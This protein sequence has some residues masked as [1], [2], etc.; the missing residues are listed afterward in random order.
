MSTML[1]QIANRV[2]GLG[3][4]PEVIRPSSDGEGNKGNDR[5]GPCDGERPD[6]KS[7]VVCWRLLGGF[8]L[9]ISGCLF[10]LGLRYSRK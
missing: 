6:K 7:V 1:E 3:G 10:L 2:R 8:A 9:F 5:G 4:G